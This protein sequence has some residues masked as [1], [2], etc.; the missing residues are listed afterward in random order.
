MGLEGDFPPFPSVPMLL[1]P[2]LKIVLRAQEALGLRDPR[3]TKTPGTTWG[4]EKS[5]ARELNLNGR[6]SLGTGWPR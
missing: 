1:T 4:P 5:R 6:K 3:V 2:V